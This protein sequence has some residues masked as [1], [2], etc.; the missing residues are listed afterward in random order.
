MSSSG[1]Q[2]E[3][4]PVFSGIEYGGKV[5]RQLTLGGRNIIRPWGVEFAD[6]SAFYSL[7]D[8]Y[9]YRYELLEQGELS[10][11]SRHEVVQVIRMREGLVR[12]ELKEWLEGPRDFRRSCRVTCLEATVLMDFVLRFRFDASGFPLGLIA[13]RILPYAGS[14]IHHQYPV[15]SAAVGNDRFSIRIAV[16][17]K[18]VPSP[19]RAY[20][21]LRDG[22]GAWVLHLRMLPV[23]WDKEVVKLCSKWFGTRPLPQCVSRPLL[24]VPGVR[25]SLWYRGER[26]P[27]RNRIACVFSPNAYPMARMAKG[28]ILRWDASCRVEES[29]APPGRSPDGD[30]RGSESC[31]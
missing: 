3:D 6:S 14:G 1:R 18:A 5:L 30:S 8:G 13:D 15:D 31:S 20:V 19:M 24:K 9:G 2:A 29:F 16:V 22:E 21:Y 25:E 26:R 12:L 27:Y 17:D 7:E 28:D 4:L 23:H 11:G 10:E